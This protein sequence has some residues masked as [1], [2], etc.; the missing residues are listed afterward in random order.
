[1][2][3]TIEKTELWY[4]GGDWIRFSGNGGVKKKRISFIPAVPDWITSLEIEETARG[5]RS[6]TM[7][8]PARPSTIRDK[9]I[10]LME[11]EGIVVGEIDHLHRT[12][13]TD[14]ILHCQRIAGFLIK[15]V[16][17]YH[18]AHIILLQMFLNRI[19]DRG[20]NNKEKVIMTRYHVTLGDILNR[21]VFEDKILEFKPMDNSCWLQHLTFIAS[22]SGRK[23][24]SL[25]I[26]EDKYE[27]II[28]TLN[29]VHK[30]GFEKE[31]DPVLFSLCQL[32]TSSNRR[33]RGI[34]QFLSTRIVFEEERYA[35][36]LEQFIKINN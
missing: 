17:F 31:D 22:P 33:L 18:D 1:M 36:V 32:T 9:M 15:H 14:S 3:T 24:I 6:I 26:K 8:F 10:K 21:S 4:E 25:K 35:S 11:S 19:E 7:T 34:A 20:M 5:L 12:L 13:H 23:S 16:K 29:E 27:E 28:K 30:L 2:T